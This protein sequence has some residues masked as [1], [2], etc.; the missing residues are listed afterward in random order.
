[1]EGQT[2]RYR[3][4]QPDAPAA[5]DLQ[6]F[7]G[8]Y[9]NDETSVVFQMAPGKDS[10]M[11]RLNDSAP[12]EFKPVDRDTF[13]RGGMILRFRRDKAGTVVTLD[14]SNPVVRNINFTRLS[15]RTSR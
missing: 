3:R 11:V 2:T 12:F 1:M 9:E 14:Y 7:A 10:V 5:A 15:D 4:A 13:Q 6:A 8:R